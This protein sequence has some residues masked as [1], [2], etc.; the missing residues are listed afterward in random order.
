MDS[1][2]Q[3]QATPNLVIEIDPDKITQTTPAN[4]RSVTP[5]DLRKDQ[6]LL[7]DIRKHGQKTP[8][9][10]R[11]LP[12]GRYELIVGTR[13]LG[14][15]RELSKLN[16]NVMLLAYVVDVDDM[17]AWRIAYAENTARKDLTPLQTARAWKYALDHF[18]EGVQEGLARAV[19]KD[20]ATVSRTLALL[21]IPEEILGAL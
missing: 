6:E 3:C 12:D 17:K 10:V 20:A 18:C 11:L 16:P 5:F 1:M 4:G 9:V 14:A 13:R 7:D 21:E 8:V 19:N 2:E 15:V